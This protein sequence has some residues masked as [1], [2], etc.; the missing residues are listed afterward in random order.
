[1][2][3][4]LEQIAILCSYN[5]VWHV[6][7]TQVGIACPC[8]P[9]MIPKPEGPAEEGQVSDHECARLSLAAYL[10]LQSVACCQTDSSSGKQGT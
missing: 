4:C 10:S 7:Y 5:I 1:M 3:K 2:G 8:S 6:K 9:V